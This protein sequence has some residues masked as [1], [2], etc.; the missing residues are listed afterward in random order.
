MFALRHDDVGVMEFV[1]AALASV[2]LVVV[3]RLLTTGVVLT[4]RK[5][6]VVAHRT[7]IIGGGEVSREVATLLARYPRYGLAVAGH[8]DSTG[9][10]RVPSPALG[11]V[12]GPLPYLG[13]LDDLDDLVRAHG[14]D[15]LLVGDGSFREEDLL[16]RVRTP[17]TEHCDLLV[18]PRMHQFRRCPAGRTTSA[19][20][21]SCASATRDCGPAITVKRVFDILVP[22]PR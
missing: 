5:R 22:A 12:V 8:V 15:V 11:P 6:R 13:S 19:R 14:V 9:P 16:D 1:A 7:M 4:A 17:A 3:G 20:S 2:V 18:V 10:G 21:R